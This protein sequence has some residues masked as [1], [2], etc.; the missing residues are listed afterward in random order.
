MG[1]G[2]RPGA[3][4]RVGGCANSA[5]RAKGALGA[6]VNALGGARAVGVGETHASV[7]G[8]GGESLKTTTFGGWTKFEWQTPSVEA[9]FG[10]SVQ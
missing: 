5:R 7:P 10:Q 3:G 2:A 9:S 4:Q 6:R 8:L 1:A